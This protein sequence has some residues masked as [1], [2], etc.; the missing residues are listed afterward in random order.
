[1]FLVPLDRPGIEIQ[2]VRTLGGE[3]T[4]ITFYNDVC[5]P[6]HARVGA[7]DGGWQVV[8]TSLAFERGSAFGA[9]SS[10]LG[11]LHR[12]LDRTIAWSK[13]AQR[14]NGPAVG[15]PDVR[16]RIARAAID[17][18]VSNVLN[19][20]SIWLADQGTIPD[21]EAS[22]AK[23]YAT[24]SLQ[25]VC[26]DLLDLAGTDGLLTWTGQGAAGIGAVE[27]AFRH[28]VVTTIYGGS[29]EIMRNIIAQRG[30][31]LPRA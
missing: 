3:R 24:E 12:V 13:Q 14:N 11:T 10:F 26:S 25:R 1:M 28:G 30:L 23:L 16:R 9:T 8:T 20:R 31:G 5:V 6:D 21:A 2:A 19:H 17:Y 22:M 18:E 4:N 29:S 27:H 7:V 15:D